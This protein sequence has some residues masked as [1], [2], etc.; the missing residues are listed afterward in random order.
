MDAYRCDGCGVINHAINDL[1]GMPHT[2]TARKPSKCQGRYARVQQDHHR[3]RAT[4]QH[5]LSPGGGDA[6]WQPT[7]A[8]SWSAI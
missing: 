5:H 7:T 6:S 2:H 1:T 8:S 4:Q 3:D